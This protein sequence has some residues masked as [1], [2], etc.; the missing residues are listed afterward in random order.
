MLRTQLGAQLYRKCIETY[1]ERHGLSS[2]GTEDLNRVIEELS[3]RSYDPFFDQWVY[4]GGEPQLQISYSWQEV[5]KLAKVTVKQTQ[6]AN[7]DVLQFRFRTKLRFKGKDWVLDRGVEITGSQHEFYV[8]LKS[9]P[10]IVRFDPEYDLLAKVNFVKPKEMLY[11]QLADTSDVVGQVL[12]VEALKSKKDK[13]TIAK[14]K[15]ALNGDPFYGV[16]IEASAALRAIRTPESFNAL[17]ASLKQEDAK[18]RL[19]V[20]NDMGAFFRSEAKT[21]ITDVLRT[22]KNP[23]IVTAAIRN[24]G[25]YPG[26]DVRKLLLGYLS[27]NS[28][29]NELAFAAVQAIRTSD[30]PD[31]IA[32]LM[33]ILKKREKEFTRRNFGTAVN[34]LAYISRNEED[35]SDVREFLSQ[36]VNHKNDRI[37]S[38]AIAALGTL[39]DPRG[40]P[41]VNSFA[42]GGDRKTRIQRVA[43]AAL[44]KLR[45]SEK[46][47]VQL[48]NLRREVITL[49]ETS[50]KLEKKLEDA[51]KRMEAKGEEQKED[52]ESEKED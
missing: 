39:K 24:L 50:E 11:A 45:E 4:H 20:V 19:R 35:R 10:D 41:V 31:F 29:R 16:R 43:N 49:K 6:K 40:I 27:S 38:S 3:G 32:P 34:T 15:T 9:K 36:V 5:D 25:K 33:S 51:L 13:K 14:L 12:A 18:I 21:R 37:Q 47:S 46:V 1:L 22:E 28:F 8:P 17:A 52:D 44:E 48:R 7:D 2:V 26:A 30:D 23:S 42:G